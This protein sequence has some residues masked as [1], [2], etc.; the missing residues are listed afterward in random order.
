MEI[1]R[2]LKLRMLREMLE[3]RYFE[4]KVKELFMEAQIRGSMHVSIGEE[5]T[6]AGA[7]LA[8]RE[9]DLMTSTHRGHGHCLAKGIGLNEMMAEILGK[10][11]GCCGGRGGSMHMMDKRCGVM[12]T[13]AVVGGAIPVA[14]GL[15]VGIQQQGLD[16]VV[17]CFLGDGACNQGSFHESVNLASVWKLPVVYI[18]VNNGF[19]DTTPYRQAVNID[20]LAVR[21]AAYGIPGVV[22]DGN[23]VVAV[24]DEVTRAAE[25]VRGG[26]GPYLIECKTYRWEGHQLGDPCVY[27]TKEEVNEWKKKCPIK[28]LAKQMI[29]AG[30]LTDEEFKAMEAA[31]LAEVQAA[32]EFAVKSP[33]PDPSTVSEYLW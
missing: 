24:Y 25:H 4:E 15:G 18:I 29:E 2:D 28:R 3:I 32:A 30:E 12:G 17:L 16:K 6:G 11:S 13:T 26:N 20:D 5:A 7:C 22:V 10:A 27:R 14:T 33:D 1:P 8:V 9:D 19:G 23:D 21:G 31:A